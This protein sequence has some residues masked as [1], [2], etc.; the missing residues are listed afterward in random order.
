MGPDTHTFTSAPK[1]CLSP[2]RHV[3]AHPL[4]GL[5]PWPD[6]LPFRALLSL[7][8][9]VSSFEKRKE[10]DP[11]DGIQHRLDPSLR[12]SSFLA[13][14]DIWLLAGKCY[15]LRNIVMIVKTWPI[16]TKQH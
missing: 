15:K 4:E 5:E 11:G 8:A 7:P 14:C 10:P 9:S 6:T 16:I 13:Q 2:Y 3:G 1:L 12:S